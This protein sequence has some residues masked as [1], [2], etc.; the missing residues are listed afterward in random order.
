MARE[1]LDS[2]RQGLDGYHGFFLAL[3]LVV[4]IVIVLT[5]KELTTAI[6]LIGLITNFLI[7]SSQLTLLGD[8]H[9]ATHGGGNCS[10]T[11]RDLANS[12]MVNFTPGGD[13]AAEGGKHSGDGHRPLASLDSLEG[14]QEGF[15]SATTALPGAGPPTMP[16]V[17]ET[18]AVAGYPGAIN[19]GKTI[20]GS[21]QAPALGHVD[22]DE[23]ARAGVP[24]GNPYSQGRVSSPQA[25]GPCVDDDAVA[26][27]DGDELMAYHGR[28]RNDPERVWVGITRRKA[29][30]SRFVKEELDETESSV[31]W[32]NHEV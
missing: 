2:P 25:A 24:E 15:T 30:V 14:A 11:D 10:Q 20:S 19:F 4:M 22:W 12:V 27:Y 23:E 8:R 3:T 18:P 5:T 32:G 6:L 21:D 29:L 7:I 1:K 16:V 31:W 13:Y 26:I 17:P 9:V 28:A